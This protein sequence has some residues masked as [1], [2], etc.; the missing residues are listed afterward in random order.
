MS[1]KKEESKIDALSLK[2]KLSHEFSKKYST[3]EG[4]INREK[5]KKDLNKM[6]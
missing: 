5:L 6:K 2:R 4:I 1:N 3:E